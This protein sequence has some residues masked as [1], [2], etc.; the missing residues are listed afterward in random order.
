MCRVTR[1]PAIV[2]ERPD[3]ARRPFL[4][5]PQHSVV[6][7]FGRAGEGLLADR[8]LRQEFVQLREFGLVGFLGRAQT[9]G[10]GLPLLPELD[11]LLLGLVASLDGFPL[12]EE[13]ARQIADLA[14]LLI[15]RVR[16]Q[17][18]QGL[19]DEAR[20]I[21][22]RQF[23]AFR[24]QAIDDLAIGIGA[25]PRRLLLLRRQ[26]GEPGI[27]NGGGL[28]HDLTDLLQIAG[29]RRDQSLHF[30]DQAF[31]FRPNATGPLV[32]GVEQL[33]LQV[34]FDLRDAP[35]P[36]LDHANVR[37]DGIGRRTGIRR[38]WRPPISLVPLH[39]GELGLPLLEC[40][41]LALELPFDVATADIVEHPIV[42]RVSLGP[43]GANVLA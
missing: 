29:I 42:Q 43:Q 13:C 1:L 5:G 30:G 21:G 35:C 23:V 14:T 26:L 15:G 22:H 38:R 9:V 2:P 39:P 41:F 33:L 10:E 28:R 18:P 31:V 32:G 27:A 7:V 12:I 19:G 25:S 6:G 3:D 17:T 8:T 34:L 4:A 16:R 24:S 11:R 36:L 20:A 37:L 40:P